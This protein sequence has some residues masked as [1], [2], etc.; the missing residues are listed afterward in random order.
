MI[1]YEL[2]HTIIHTTIKYHTQTQIQRP[3]RV[4]LLLLYL[5][6]VRRNNTDKLKR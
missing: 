3:A 4:P 1:I 2:L 5:S 6:F